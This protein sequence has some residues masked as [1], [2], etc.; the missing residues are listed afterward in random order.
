GLLEKGMGDLAQA[1]KR[2]ERALGIVKQRL[3]TEA[4]EAANIMNDLALVLELQG[5]KDEA[6]ELFSSALEIWERTRGPDH[7]SVALV[8]HN[9]GSLANQSGD[10]ITGRVYLERSLAIRSAKLGSDNPDVATTLIGLANAWKGRR[11]YAQAESL[12]RRALA[13][14]ESAFG[15]SHPAVAVDLH[16]LAGVL[17][18][19]GTPAA[20][21]D[22]ALVVEDIPREHFRLMARALSEGEALHYAAVR[23]KG[24]DMALTCAA[25]TP[26]PLAARR[27]WDSVIRSRALVLD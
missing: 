2:F 4:P 13:I 9:L 6:R 5:R 23:V 8:L 20:A 16:N 27:V 15:R 3:G 1:Q 26:D 14:H 19:P 22:T 7:P 10:Y 17:P 18:A 24:L 21:L 25:R 11:D 12:Y